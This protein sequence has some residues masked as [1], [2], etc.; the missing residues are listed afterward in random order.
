MRF[1]QAFALT[2]TLWIATA[3]VA[4][5]PVA[6]TPVAGMESQVLFRLTG[7]NTIGA[8]LAPALV[9]GYL[10]SLN[11]RTITHRSEGERHLVRAELHGRQVEVP[12]IA[13]GSGTGFKALDA[14]TTDIAM[15][16]RRI[17]E[18]EINRL[19]RFGDM[20]GAAAEHVIGLDALVVAVHPTNSVRQLALGDLR[21]IY[22][23]KIRNWRELGGADLA[24]RPLHRDIESGTRATFDK[25]V[26]GAGRPAASHVY[27]VSGNAETHQLITSEA[28]AIGYLPFADAAD[29]HKVAIKAGELAAVVPHR[30]IVAT[31]DFPLTRRLYLYRNP[32]HYD[33]QVDGFLD[34]VES[35]VGQALVAQ[36]GFID[37]SPVTL[38]MAPYPNAPE[39]YQSLMREAE[40]LSISFR[41]TDGSAELDNRALKDLRRL[42][43]FLA[44]A[45]R[46][47]ELTLVGFSDQRSSDNVSELISRFRA[48]K[49]R[50]ALLRDHDISRIRVLA[51]GA[52]APLTADAEHAPLKN[53]RVEVWVR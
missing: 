51:L 7:S 48:L 49:V 47:V 12:I 46:E 22:S 41:F 9:M 40:R 30:G 26:F 14:G 17:K 18:G 10:E 39:A 6:G 23:G 43:E 50:G 24:I 37:L 29:I 38:K 21:D 8:E 16:S 36:T 11:A 34:F 53:G 35:G 4:G 25:E 33:P 44:Q 52:F 32:G 19:G 5:T 2:L 27:E 28:A 15:A 45:D 20:T 13:L 31:E 1:T 42:E 3:P